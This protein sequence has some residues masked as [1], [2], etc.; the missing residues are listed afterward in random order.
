MHSRRTACVGILLPASVWLAACS[1]GTEPDA[2]DVP[3]TRLL[4]L[5][6]AGVH[7]Q[8]LPNGVEIAYRTPF[9]WPYDGPPAHVKAVHVGTGAIRT[10]LPPQGSTP[11]YQYRIAHPYLYFDLASTIYRLDLTSTTAAIEQSAVVF[12]VETFNWSVSD[13]HRWIAWTDSTLVFRASLASGATDT[14]NT[15]RWLTGRRTFLAPDGSAILVAEWGAQPGEVHWINVTTGSVTSAPTP[16]MLSDGALVH[17]ENS[18]P[19]LYVACGGTFRRHVVGAGSSTMA[20]IAGEDGAWSPEADRVSAWRRS[21]PAWTGYVC[22]G[23][24]RELSV[25]TVGGQ[26]RVI[27]TLVLDA[28]EHIHDTGPALFSPGGPYIA[29]WLNT[30]TSQHDGLRV[31]RID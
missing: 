25:A 21:C 16:C 19:V 14:I 8:W 13:D 30:G 18:T 6:E 27:G 5:H 15:D 24:R 7:W 23:A 12:P 4:D 29:F 11:V 20:S 28:Q 17:W 10:L 22:R 3:G 26:P 2:H 9:D 1:L 31:L